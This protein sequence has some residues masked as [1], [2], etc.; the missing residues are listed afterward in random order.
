[1][2]APLL[3][4]VFFD[5]GSS[6][7]PM[8]Y[9]QFYSASATSKYID[10]GV[11]SYWSPVTKY[12]DILNVLG[13]RMNQHPSTF[14]ELQGSWSFEPGE[15]MAL[16]RERSEVIRDYLV[17]IWKI[18]PG[19]IR[20]IDPKRRCSE[21]ENFFL[22]EEGQAVAISPSSW[23]LIRPVSFIN[24][25]QWY[26]S[27]IFNIVVDPNDNPEQV[28]AIE[29]LARCEDSLVGRMEIVG[30]PDST[31]YRIK[32]TWGHSFWFTEKDRTALEIEAVVWRH[33]GTT[34][35]SAPT[36]LPVTIQ[37][38]TSDIRGTSGIHT[39]IGREFT[40]PFFSPN[41]TNLSPVQKLLIRERLTQ[42]IVDT[43]EPGYKYNIV[44]AGERDVS[45][46]PTLHDGLIRSHRI[47]YWSAQT[48]Y[49]SFFDDFQGILRPIRPVLPVE[50]QESD[51]S[52]LNY[53]EQLKQLYRN[54]YGERTDDMM[55]RREEYDSA[56]LITVDIEEGRY[57]DTL[58]AAREG[59]A[60]NI[61]QDIFQDQL[62]DTVKRRYTR[63]LYPPPIPPEDTAG[64]D[65]EE[66]ENSDRI[67]FGS[68]NV[69]WKANVGVQTSFDFMYTPEERFYTRAVTV[70]IDMKYTPTPEQLAA[71]EEEEKRSYLMWLKEQTGYAGE[72]WEDIDALIAHLEEQYYREEEEYSESDSEE[73]DE[74]S[75]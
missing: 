44:V 55:R 68:D 21:E 9:H 35:R 50:P 54:F 17:D 14:I 66:Y 11:G 42:I 40:L 23:E 38:D 48:S 18:D 15:S 37:S 57:L 53:E 1:M 20:L 7:I 60:A 61:L 13:Y 47:A 27:F 26:A 41:Q 12:R 64:I 46:A 72:D 71:E 32:G 45:D 43:L 5:F 74:E 28:A 33:D 30:S 75:E 69:A 39:Y 51:D 2:E 36:R 52:S 19:R 22:Q 56:A 31:L 25:N 70:R 49:Q 62:N 29:I 67:T 59:D 24:V 34:R 65:I 10:T 3:P 4:I 58:R 63:S 8:R 16:A 73:Y 6:D